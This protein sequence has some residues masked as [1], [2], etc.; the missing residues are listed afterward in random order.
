[1]STDDEE[2]EDEDIPKAQEEEESCSG[3]EKDEME[4]IS[5][6]EAP[7][8][9]QYDREFDMTEEKLA[10]AHLKGNNSYSRPFFFIPRFQQTVIEIGRAHV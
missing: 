2:E 4:S 7:D 9:A 1:M 5:M 3:S 6:S 10:L 8:I